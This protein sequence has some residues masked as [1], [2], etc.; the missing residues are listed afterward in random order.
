MKSLV[1][2]AIIMLLGGCEQQPRLNKLPDD[3]VI[4]AFGDSLT[5]GTGVNKE[6]SYP[7][8]LSQ[9]TDRQVINAG[10][11]GEISGDGL[12]RL[13]ELLD[14]YQPELLILIHGGNDFIRRLPTQQTADNI[15]QMIAAARQRNIDVILLGVP[16]PG[17]LLMSSAELYG[18]ISDSLQIANDLET[19]PEILATPSLKSDLVHPNAQGYRLLAENISSLLQE[20]G[21]I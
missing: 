8:I 5:Y 1:I 9:L 2:V 12:T 16:Q 6:Q 15:R 21:A 17:L 20:R 7:T 13:P 11:P 19:L 4:L 10:I 14:E 18:R 3:A